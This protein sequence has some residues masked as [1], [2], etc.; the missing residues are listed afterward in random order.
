MKKVLF[1]GL[2][3]FTIFAFGQKVKLKKDIVYIDE[4][5]CFAYESKNLANNNIISTLDGEKLFF[6]D[7]IDQNGVGSRNNEA[8]IKV[9]FI[10]S[11]EIS[12]MPN[13]FS[14]K[15][16][17]EGMIDVGVIDKCTFKKEKIP[18]FIKRFDQR[19]EDSI[20]RVSQ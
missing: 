13:A 6:I 7:L 5:K 15:E 17:I 4:Q 16:I 19:Y 8:Y 11:D 3:I 18:N 9:S 1:F 2:M 14:R 12:T 10:D 20:I